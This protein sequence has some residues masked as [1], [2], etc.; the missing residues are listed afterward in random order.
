M[1]SEAISVC[2]PCVSGGCDRRCVRDR[3]QLYD[4]CV[5]LNKGTWLVKQK[6]I[7][8]SR[9]YR[10]S[11]PK[12]TKSFFQTKQLFQ[13]IDKRKCTVTYKKYRQARCPVCDIRKV[14][15]VRKHI[16]IYIH[17]LLRQA[18]RGLGQG[19]VLEQK[20]NQSSFWSVRKASVDRDQMIKVDEH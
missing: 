13:P 11:S 6:S 10:I 8:E 12:Q 16:E 4:Y 20:D 7:Y 17:Y 9:E 19:I 15:K 1:T 14:E 5:A 2:E 3:K 18:G